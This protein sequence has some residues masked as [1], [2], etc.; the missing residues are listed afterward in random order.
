VATQRVL[1]IAGSARKRLVFASSSS[2]YGD[3]ARHPTP[4]GTIPQ[5]VSPYGASKLACEV[6]CG[7]YAR[8]VGVET[9]ILRYFTVY[10]P[11]QR[12]DMAFARIVEA[13]ISGSSFEVFGDGH[14]S[15]DFTYVDDVVTATRAAMDGAP[16]GAI[17]NVGGGA[18]ASLRDAIEIL[19]DEAGCTLDAN[20]SGKAKGDVRRTLAATERIRSDLGWAPGTSLEAGLRRQVRRTIARRNGSRVAA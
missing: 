2:I 9:V 14:Q 10:G 3:A 17:Y 7:A 1:E 16:A 11:R 15:R 13:L 5:P 20:F 18:E 19:Q 4:E 12:P 6:L 8:S